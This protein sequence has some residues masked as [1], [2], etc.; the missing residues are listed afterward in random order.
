LQAVGPKIIVTFGKKATKSFFDTFESG[1]SFNKM[2][3]VVLNVYNINSYKVIPSYH[4]SNLNRNVGSLDDIDDKQEYWTVL[5]Q[6]IN[7]IQK[8]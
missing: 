7:S 4:W 6:R 2:K 1:T 5:A 3:D 8:P